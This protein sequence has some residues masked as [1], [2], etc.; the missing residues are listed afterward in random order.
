MGWIILFSPL[1]AC[2]VITL[3][4]LQNKKL[5][6]FIAILGLLISFICSVSVF[7]QALHS[8]GQVLEYNLNWIS[9]WSLQIEFGILLDPLSILMLLIVTG[10]GSAIFI[11]SLGYMSEDRSQP[12]YFA[13]LSL[14]A[15]SMLGIILSNNL[16]QT[17][18]F[19]EL[20]GASSYLL[21]GFWFEKDSAADAGNKAF[22]VNRVGDFGFVIGILMCWMISGLGTTPKTFNFLKIEHLFPQL[23]NQGLVSAG[24][25]TLIGL[26]IFCGVLGKSAQF[27][28]HVWL[29][30]AMEG[31][32]PVSALIHAATMVAAGI[33]L[34]A[35]LFFLFE[36]SPEAMQII[37]YVG[38][39]TSIF[40]ASLALVQND[41]KRILAYSTLSQ[42][43]LMVMA[44]GLGGKTA[45]MFHLATHAFFKALLFLG[46]GSII[47]A[48]HTQ[49]IWNMGKLLKKMPIT[50]I[51]FLIGSLALCG[52]FPLSGFW[53]KD[54]ILLTAYHKS[55][56]LYMIASIT[57]WMTSFYMA[58]ACFV[59]ILAPSKAHH[60]AHESGWIMKGPLV[61]LTLGALFSGFIGIPHFITG[62]ASQGH[63]SINWNIA[64]ISQIS[65]LTALVFAYFLY[66]IRDGQGAKK[67]KVIF[68]FPYQIL[69]KKYFID[70]IYQWMVD[71][72]QQTIAILCNLFDQNVII[73]FGVNGTARTTRACG[74]IL[75]F[76]QTG[77]VQTYALVFFAGIT[78]IIFVM[79]LR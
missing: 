52:F 37:S 63:V 32:T 13:S 26:L 28:L 5:S 56:F 45:G 2:L 64:L 11:Y 39:F 62:P 55:F 19:W 31:P 27:P 57:S 7:L 22:L 8:P 6:G 66:M 36:V 15:F 10:I 60:H 40:A 77:R 20:V 25:L 33:Y 54:E 35:R 69:H 49:D 43:G 1:I 78:V 23:I 70:E 24:L 74:E 14:F 46:A 53:S 34:L 61:F 29:P 75:R 12:R 50:S 3:V 79:I 58:R 4:T 42:L 17:F 67:L 9:L 16:I 44:M 51:T 41:I 59:A 21:I 73:R 68:H 48:L 71:R 72:V 18:I 65:A 76:C 30:D 47:H 38:A